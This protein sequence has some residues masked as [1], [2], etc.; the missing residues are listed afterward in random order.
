MISITNFVNGRT[1]FLQSAVLQKTQKSNNQVVQNQ[2]NKALL[3]CEMMQA[4]GYIS[5]GH[6]S[7][8]R[9]QSAYERLFDTLEK[10]QKSPSATDLEILINDISAQTVAK[11]QDIEYALA[12]LTQF[13]NMSSLKKIADYVVNE[14]PKDLALKEKNSSEL[15]PVFLGYPM[16]RDLEY[17]C[18]FYKFSNF[19]DSK[20]IS[21]NTA[22]TYLQKEKQQIKLHDQGTFELFVLDDA[23]FEYLEKLKQNPDDFERLCS[24]CKFVNLEGW[25]DGINVFSQTNDLTRLKNSA[26]N[27]IE[28]AKEIQDSEDLSFNNAFDKAINAKVS[29]RAEK[30]GIEFSTISLKADSGSV[31]NVVKNLEPLKLE[32]SNVKNLVKAISKTLY[33]YDENDR[34]KV[35]RLIAGYLQSEIDIYTPQRM[36]D[37]LKEIHDDLEKAITKYKKADGSN[38]TMNDVM[39]VIPHAGRSYTPV[40]L[41][42][43]SINNVPQEQF[44]FA[45]NKSYNFGLKNDNLY[46]I[47]DD[48]A[49]SGISY[50]DNF[51]RNLNFRNL[52]NSHFIFAPIVAGETAQKHIN[53]VIQLRKRSNDDLFLIDDKDVRKKYFHTEFYETLNWGRRTELTSILDKFFVG[54]RYGGAGLNEALVKSSIDLPYTQ[55][56]GGGYAVCLPY[57]TPASNAVMPNLFLSDLL[58]NPNACGTAVKNYYDMTQPLYKKIMANLRSIE[59]E[60]SCT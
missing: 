48:A 27:L 56:T 46:V 3:S 35:E 18:D 38:Y 11:K 24:K 26:V 60:N 53:N 19:Y 42:Y 1:H 45:N 32:E 17:L 50:V 8:G 6:S 36:G 28:R 55:P 20:N 39:Y 22:L 37:R 57:M 25:M 33:A 44:V 54:S 16:S 10:Q 14:L 58:L 47:L 23:G 31:N 9:L 15:D 29:E 13:G 21:A 2:D 51:Y 34:I 4:N 49:I 30:L 52:E 41:Q 43:A 40:A 12:K 59:N 7:E 5:F